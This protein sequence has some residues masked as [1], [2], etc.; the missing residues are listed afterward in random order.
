M[1]AKSRGIVRYIVD[2]II[3]LE[4]LIIGM[5]YYVQS[6]ITMFFLRIIAGLSVLLGVLQLFD[7]IF[8]FAEYRKTNLIYL[9]FIISTLTYAALYRNN[10]R[11]ALFFVSTVM[12]LYYVYCKGLDKISI[13]LLLCCNILLVI[14]HIV[15]AQRQD[16]FGEFYGK[17]SLVTV[18][19]N[20]NMAGIV[21]TST[22]FLLVAGIFYVKR[23]II[24]LLFIILSLLSIILL[25]RTGNRG[26]M[27]SVIVL[28]I[29]L[30]INSKTYKD[31]KMATLLL[32][33]SPI[34]ITF[35]Y[36]SMSSLFPADSV[37]F[38]KFLFTRPGWDLAVAEIIQDPTGTSKLFGGGLN[39]AIAGVIEYGILGMGSFF[40]L[41][42]CMKPKCILENKLQYQQ[43]AYLAFL[44]VFIQ[45]AFESTLVN[46]AYGLY[47]HTYLLLG[48]ANTKTE[49]LPSDRFKM[50]TINNLKQKINGFDNE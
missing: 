9:F 1:T 37:V 34:L 15:G 4:A 10:I 24:R 14:V 18:W 12:F 40:L 46:G 32:I 39:I 17:N 47:I 13:N 41:L 38:G 22:L 23:R 29:M 5:S 48:I 43:V 50:S 20:P 33:L 36:V 30:I 49:H 3:V 7:P 21:I 28:V 11:E 45:Q 35:V 26:S 25:L 6:E 16:A 31:R 27:V 19:E 8:N 42:V 44:S 2:I